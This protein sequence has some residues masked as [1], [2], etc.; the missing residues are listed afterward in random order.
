MLSRLHSVALMEIDA[1]FY[2]TVR[3]PAA[4]L[5]RRRRPG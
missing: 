4:R 3:D 2:M 5:M 1:T